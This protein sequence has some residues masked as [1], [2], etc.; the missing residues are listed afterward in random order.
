M[1]PD[2]NRYL[3]ALSKNA[4]RSQTFYEYSLL[5]C[6]LS[7]FW[8]NNA[9][10]SEIAADLSAG[11]ARKTQQVATVVNA[12]REL[13]GVFLRRKNLIELRCRVNFPDLA[14]SDE[15]ETILR[16]IERKLARFMAEDG[17]I[18][19]LDASIAEWSEEWRD[20]VETATF[21]AAGTQA[22][23]RT[24]T[25]SFKPKTGP[26]GSGQGKAPPPAKGRG[27]AAP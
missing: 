19:V 14:H 23:K 26:R 27:A 13:Y 1:S 15:D 12:N 6:T 25:S 17:D 8:D 11:S 5:H 4:K 21:S 9:Y 2:D 7:F 22:A 3:K 20:R 16:Q 10:L 18:D 24:S